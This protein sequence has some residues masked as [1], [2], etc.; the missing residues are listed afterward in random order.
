NV[1]PLRRVVL[2]LD[3][4]RKLVLVFLHGQ[5]DFL[6]RRLALAPWHIRPTAAWSLVFTAAARA[7]AILKMKAGDPLVI[8]DHHGDRGLAVHSVVMSDVE[9]ERRIRGCR[10]RLLESGFAALT[11]G[12]EGDPQPALGSIF[13]D[14]L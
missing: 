6:E 8:L 14:A 10:Q 3:A 5:Q 13:T 9:I 7:L 1:G 11:M 4:G 12:V 2:V